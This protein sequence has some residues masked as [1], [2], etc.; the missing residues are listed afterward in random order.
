MKNTCIAKLLT[1]CFLAGCTGVPPEWGPGEVSHFYELKDYDEASKIII[2]N[3]KG[4]NDS[5]YFPHSLNILVHRGL[6]NKDPKAF[7]QA[8]QAIPDL[9]KQTIDYYY[10]RYAQFIPYLEKNGLTPVF[11]TTD[12]AA[13]ASNINYLRDMNATAAQLRFG[14]AD[15]ENTYWYSLYVNSICASPET[16]AI[17]IRNLAEL[18]DAAT[19]KL[20]S[21]FLNPN[22]K[23]G[24][25]LVAFQNALCDMRELDSRYDL[26]NLYK[27]E[28][29]D[30]F[31][32]KV[33]IR[34]E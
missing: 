28:S 22:G 5:D 18:D 8:M 12:K 31:I 34:Y 27:L 33:P 1:V 25:E 9:N 3:G 21:D 14:T 20:L 23:F 6:D 26:S 17:L 30:A 29:S 2:Q 32:C 16:R 19:R 7:A 10:D 11:A 24:N 13:C 4:Y 15:L